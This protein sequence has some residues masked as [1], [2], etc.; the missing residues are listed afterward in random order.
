MSGVIRALEDP[1]T[2]AGFYALMGLVLVLEKLFDN[3]FATRYRKGFPEYVDR[4][5][6]KKQFKKELSECAFCS[7]PAS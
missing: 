4:G 5:L 7:H 6:S 2:A 1:I 3:G